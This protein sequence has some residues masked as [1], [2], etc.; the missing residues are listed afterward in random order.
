MN[1]RLDRSYG[2][3]TAN[4]AAV[5]DVASTSAHHLSSMQAAVQ[6]AVEAQRHR[7]SAAIAA[8]DAFVHRN[9]SDVAS[10]KV[11]TNCYF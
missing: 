5:A 4:S 3:E 1:R 10:L 7:S 11:R 2:R 6:T 9:M 8:L